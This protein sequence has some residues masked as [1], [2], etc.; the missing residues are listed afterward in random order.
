MG[1]HDHGDSAGDERAEG[2]QLNLVQ[3]LEVVLHHRQVE[4]AVEQR[5]AMAGEVLGAGDDA[6]LEEPC[7]ERAGKL[8]DH[9]RVLREG[10]VADDRVLRVGPDVGIGGV[11]EVETERLELRAENLADAHRKSRIACLADLQ[12]GRD[13][14][15]RLLQALHPATLLVHRHEG[16]QPFARRLVDLVVEVGDLRRLD[17]VAGKED[18]AADVAVG[19]GRTDRAGQCGAVEADNQHLAGVAGEIVDHAKPC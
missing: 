2:R 16:E 4:V 15:Q 11:V 18:G 10:T 3:P 5:V 14:G 12:H 8:R 17:D 13:A 9:M 1:R 7:S 6:S 19:E